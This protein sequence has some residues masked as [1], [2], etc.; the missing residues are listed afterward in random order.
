MFV[1]PH[2]GTRSHATFRVGVGVD[3]A[4]RVASMNVHEAAVADPSFLGRLIGRDLG[5]SFEIDHGDLR[6]V[7][8]HT[9]KSQLVA[10]GAR[11]ALLFMQL[12][13]GRRS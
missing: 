8:G 13:L 12:A 2:N 5:S 11:E 6:G 7:A 1:E 3:T 10:S 4:G 9:T